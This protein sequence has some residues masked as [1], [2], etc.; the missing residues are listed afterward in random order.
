MKSLKQASSKKT[1]SP[2]KQERA[3]TN[4]VPLVKPKQTRPS[5]TSNKEGESREE[6]MARL[7]NA[8]KRRPR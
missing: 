7:L 6:K 5:D 3:K 4:D 1:T 8:K 2:P